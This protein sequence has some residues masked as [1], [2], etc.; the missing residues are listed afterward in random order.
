VIKTM[1]CA[2]ARLALGVYVL[3]A[4]DPAE[5]TLVDAHLA[6]CRDCRDELAGLAGLPALLARVSTEEAI[7]LA[8]DGPAEQDV[9]GIGAAGAAQA[10]AA[11]TGVPPRAGAPQTGAKNAA[12]ASA[13]AATASAASAAGGGTATDAVAATGA[14]GAAASVA[15][16]PDAQEPPRELLGTV[17]DLTAARRRRRNWRNAS[18][19]AAAAVIIAAAAFGGAHLAASQGVNPG[20]AARASD[21]FDYGNAVTSWKTSHGETA[22]MYAA[23]NYRG[24]SWGVQ[25]AA[26]VV[27]VPVGTLCRLIVVGQDGTKTVAG[28]WTTDTA[29]GTVYYPGSA[30]V[31]AQSIREFQITVAGRPTIVIPS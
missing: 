17:L 11:S 25:L 21:N 22:G 6:T 9:T 28:A 5:R 27:G 2:E 3:G 4:I 8:E 12:E 19:S 14:A 13:I 20:A 26:K 7:A 16:S 23:V 18:L 29:E 1:D 24:M 10:G 15:A 30:G 31:P